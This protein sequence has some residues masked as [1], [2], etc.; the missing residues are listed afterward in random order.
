M[1]KKER[2]KRNGRQYGIAD[3]DL[4][5]PGMLQVHDLCLRDLSQKETPSLIFLAVIVISPGKYCTSVSFLP[6]YCCLYPLDLKFC[7]DVVY[8]QGNSD[9][10]HYFIN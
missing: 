5:K 10:T 1:S 9:I 4:F 2:Y 7:C 8:A 6:F 3:Q